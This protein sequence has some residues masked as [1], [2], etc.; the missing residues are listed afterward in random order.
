MAELSRRPYLLRA[1]YEWMVDCGN[2]P[3]AIVDATQPGVKVPTAFVKDGRIVLN[4]SMTATQGLQ[5]GAG[6]FAFY[7]RHGYLIEN[8]QLTRPIK[9]VNIIGNGPK[10]LETVQMVGN[11][12][13]IDVGGWTCGKDGQSV[14]VGVGQPTLRIDGV[15]VG[16]TA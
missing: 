5:I 4:I 2:T 9:D 8:G 10:V 12:L 6:D 7:V 13:T 16:G 3:H 11:D 14:P 15:T 1:M